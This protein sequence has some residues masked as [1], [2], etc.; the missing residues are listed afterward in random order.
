MKDDFGDAINCFAENLEDF[1]D[2][3]TAAEKYNLYSGLLALARGLQQLEG[4]V[5]SLTEAVGQI[6]QRLHR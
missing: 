6:R 4:H 2:E 1:A 3:Q 5:E